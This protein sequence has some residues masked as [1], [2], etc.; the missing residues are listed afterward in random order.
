VDGAQQRSGGDR[1]DAAPLDSGL[2]F[3]HAG[4]RVT[5]HGPVRTSGSVSQLCPSTILASR[6]LAVSRRQLR[7]VGLGSPMEKRRPPGPTATDHPHAAATLPRTWTASASTTA[8]GGPSRSVRSGPM[9]SHGRSAAIRSQPVLGF[10]GI[11]AVVATVRP[12]ALCPPSTTGRVSM[13][14]SVSRRNMLCSGHC[15][16]S[17]SQA[18]NH[19]TGRNCA[20]RTLQ[21]ALLPESLVAQVGGEC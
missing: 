20:G 14:A 1:S 4:R 17:R 21:A 6:R 11:D 9:V 13:P 19:N 5:A 12:A 7:W 8:F 10:H 15:P 18:A 16:C 2:G 3:W